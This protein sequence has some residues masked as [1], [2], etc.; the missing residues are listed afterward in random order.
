MNHSSL[1]Q[2][3]TV[4]SGYETRTLMLPDR[5]EGMVPAT[6]V[7]R[8]AETPTRRAV[9]YVH[10]FADYFFQ[11]H[12]AEQFIAAGYHFY[13]L[14]LRRCGR[15]LRP[16]QLPNYIDQLREYDDE[17]NVAIEVLYGD[18][19]V[20]WLLLSGHSTGG[21]IASLYGHH[22][23]R[24]TWVDAFFLNSPFF[25]FN[26][27]ALLRAILLPAIVGVS[28]VAPG[29]VVSGLG[30]NYG[31]SIHRSHYGEWDFDLAWKPLAGVQARAAWVRAVHEGQSQLARGLKIA[32]PILLMH[33]DRSVRGMRWSDDLRQADAVLNVADMRRLASKLGSQVSTIEIAGGLHDLVLSA[34][35]VR[36]RVFGELF[37]WLRQL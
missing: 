29:L 31:R 15:S 14:D 27:T 28:R 34:E 8:R 33:S 21:L 2:P 5:Y 12:M 23:R 35:P 18:E 37:A 16:G 25:A 17:L 6:L 36:S 4:L 26:Q 24:R 10:G 32:Q 1:W 11:S 7:R 9:L 22:G 20:D 13:A 30:E 3:D 19:G